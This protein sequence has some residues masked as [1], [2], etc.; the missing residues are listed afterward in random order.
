MQWKF[1]ANAAFLGARRDRFNQYQPDRSLAERLTL[2]SGIEGVPG[3]ELKYPADFEDPEE[4]GALLADSG[5]RLSAVNVNTK[6]V[7]F[8]RHGALSARDPE[9][10]RHAVRLL[11]E[12]MDLAA[13]LGTSVVTTCPLA[14]GYNYPFELDHAAAWGRFI[15]TVREAGSHRSDVRLCL[16][17]Q[18]RDPYS[19]ILLS[20]VGKVLHVLAEVALP[21]VGA[22]LDVGH[23]FAAGES[24]AESAALLAQAGRLF[25]MHTNDN[26]A[27]GGDWDMM[28]GA[29]H[30]WHWLELLCTLRRA[31]YE[32]W[33]SA[34]IDARRSSPQAA[35]E[36]NF[37]LIRRLDA[38]VDRLGAE[39]IAR[40]VE[41]DSDPAATYAFL[42]SFLD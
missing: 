15:D 24:P 27:D 18:P 1:A 3:V 26:P 36:S 41:A 21:N 31:G 13:N 12:G 29:V 8:F 25:Y 9:A 5:L 6:D 2:V 14:D 35:F 28:S 33:F 10:R 40:R 17:Y 22:N 11:T 23:A 37:L 4:T 16:E 30:F 32:G 39:E 19:H 20:N 34:D 7:T 42:S 38:L